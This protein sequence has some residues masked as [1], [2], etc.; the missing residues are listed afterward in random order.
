M[1]GFGTQLI[2]EHLAA[3]VL[4]PGMRGVTYAVRVDNPLQPVDENRGNA[5]ERMWTEDGLKKLAITKL[6]AGLASV[7]GIQVTP[8]SLEPNVQFQAY[9]KR[10]FSSPVEN[11]TV[12]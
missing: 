1:D 7:F 9:D 3:T 2:P 4:V 10:L 8:E 11:P 6:I 5:R 12:T